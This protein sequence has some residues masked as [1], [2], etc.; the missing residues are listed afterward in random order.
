MN[1]N[2]NKQFFERGQAEGAGREEAGLEGGRKIKSKQGKGR[3]NEGRKF[4]T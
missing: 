4:I 1:H 3:T 2:N